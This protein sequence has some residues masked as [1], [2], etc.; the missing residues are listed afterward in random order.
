M[1]VRSPM[2]NTLIFEKAGLLNNY[3]T[4]VLN[5][6]LGMKIYTIEMPRSKG[7]TYVLT[8]MFL[9]SKTNPRAEVQHFRRLKTIES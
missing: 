7:S 9:T 4:P 8:C 1:R 3:Y 5:I 6:Y 2:I